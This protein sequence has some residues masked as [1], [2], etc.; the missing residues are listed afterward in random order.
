MNS[1]I[2]VKNKRTINTR[3]HDIIKDAP[4]NDSK[5]ILLHMHPLS[6]RNVVF[7]YIPVLAIGAY[8]LCAV[9]L[10]SGQ[11]GYFQ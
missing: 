1:S 3:S 2:N 11:T 5:F 9:Y 4:L 10:C 8:K 7:I 6:T